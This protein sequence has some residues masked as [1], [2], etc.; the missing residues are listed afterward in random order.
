MLEINTRVYSRTQPSEIGIIQKTL[1]NGLY[2]VFISGEDRIIHEKDLR[3]V[4]R[5]SVIEEYEKIDSGSFGDNDDL[6]ELIV[7]EKMSGKLTNIYYSMHAGNTDFYPHQFKPVLQFIESISNQLVIADEVGLGKTIEALYIWKEMQ[8]RDHARNLVIFCPSML[9]EKWKHDMEF[10]F[11]LDAEIVSSDV[12]TER[13]IEQKSKA[14]RNGFSLICSLESLRRHYNKDHSNLVDLLEKNEDE[15]TLFDLVIF[16]E[17][18]YLRNP[19]TSSFKMAQK[20]RGCTQAMILLSA[21]PIQTSSKNLYT[22]LQLVAPEHFDDERTFQRFLVRNSSVLRLVAELQNPIWNPVAVLENIKATAESQIIHPS[23]INEARLACTRA[24][25]PPIEQRI[26]LAHRIQQQSYL[27]SYLT[28]SRKMEV[29]EN[30]VKRDSKTVTFALTPIEEELYSKASKHLHEIYGKNGIFAVIVKQRLIASCLPIGIGNLYKHLNPEDIKFFLQEHGDEFNNRDLVESIKPGTYPDINILKR[31]DSKYQ[32][33]ITELRSCLKPI[34]KENK[35]II[36]TGFRMTADYLSQR[37]Q[38]EEHYHVSYIHGGMGNEKYHIID[39][40]KN[41][42]EPRILLSTEVGSEGIDLQFCDTIINYDL[43]W[44]P[45]RIEQRIGRIDRIGQTSSRIKIRNI[46][47]KNTIEDRILDRLYTRVNLFENTIGSLDDILGIEVEKLIVDLSNKKLSDE[48]I[49][50]QLAQNESVKAITSHLKQELEEK[51]S[52]LASVGQYIL[53]SIKQSDAQKHYIT[54]NDIFSYVHRFLSRSGNSE[55]RI[56]PH[57]TEPYYYKITLPQETK[58]DMRKFCLNHP[59]LKGT[60]LFSDYEKPFYVYFQS[61]DT[62]INFSNQYSEIIDVEHPLIKYI[63]VK[64]QMPS[65]PRKVCSV[66]HIDKNITSTVSLLRPGLYTYYIERW[67]IDGS[68][69]IAELKY[70]LQCHDITTDISTEEAE[71]AIN[72]AAQN[73]YSGFEFFSYYNKESANNCFKDILTR[74]RSDYKSFS[75]EYKEKTALY[76]EQRESFI[77]LSFDTKIN[78]NKELYR[79]LLSEDKPNIARLYQG[80]IE[81]LTRQKSVSLDEIRS[82][83]IS[84]SASPIAV[85]LICIR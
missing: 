56:E 61:K 60:R 79:Q 2:L 84:I 42:V 26:S 81:K 71:Q 68:L 32:S 37:I 43:P 75:E 77:N 51:A 59:E 12:L 4:E 65:N 18:H 28:R 63:G 64:M 23:L 47:C 74:C 55:Y 9:R 34:P 41:A 33:L 44:N 1:E 16:D 3:V 80:K 73:G 52:K 78:K 57:E 38:E 29:F 8:V 76:K 39:Q 62:R 25:A 49:D 27:S 85:G 40:F 5:Y 70:Y 66:I 17:A 24:T 20:I 46:I 67:M 50:E 7:R 58:N 69:K 6:N 14:R 31:I 48:E 19:A 10:R 21:T 15:A 72:L 54:Q 11:G 13:I 30:R 22:L 45:M 83:E 35:V 36:F 53:E 82:K